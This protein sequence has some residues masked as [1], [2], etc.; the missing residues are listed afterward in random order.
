MSCRSRLESGAGENKGPAGGR[1][2]LKGAHRQA[3]VLDLEAEFGVLD[4]ETELAAMKREMGGVS[5]ASIGTGGA[6]R[7]DADDLEED[8]DGGDEDQKK[9]KPKKVPA[10]KGKTK[11]KK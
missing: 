7:D 5:I 2:G 1:L 10:K 4:F 9:A 6:A 8:G 3:E 11:K